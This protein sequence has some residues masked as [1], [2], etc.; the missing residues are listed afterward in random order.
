MPK[1]SWFKK[2]ECLNKENNGKIEDKEVRD[3]TSLD[4][5]LNYTAGSSY[6]RYDYM[7]SFIEELVSLIGLEISFQILPLLQKVASSETVCFR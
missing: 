2:S 7:R 3:K 4:D 1:F 6:S 5:G